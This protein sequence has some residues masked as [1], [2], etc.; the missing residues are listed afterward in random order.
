MREIKMHI[1][2]AARSWGEGGEDTLEDLDTD[3]GAIGAILLN[4]LNSC[5]PKII[6]LR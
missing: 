2:I 4:L 3:G 1:K 6:P 5:I